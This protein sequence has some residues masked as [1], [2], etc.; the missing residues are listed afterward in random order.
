[1]EIVHEQSELER[2]M[3][4]AVKVSNDSP[5]LLD[6]F[7]NDARAPLLFGRVISLVRQ[8]HPILR[9]GQRSDANATF[10]Q[11]STGAVI[12]VVRRADD[13]LLAFGPLSL[14]FADRW[15]STPEGR[16]GAMI[17]LP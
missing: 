12:K 8:R 4:E 5:V 10:F 14:V 3:R 7:L 16:T 15:E 9:I 6:R 17:A 11:F 1:M 2:Y 13:A